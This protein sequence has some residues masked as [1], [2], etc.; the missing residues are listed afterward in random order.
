MR[1][2]LSI[3]FIIGIAILTMCCGAKQSPIPEDFSLTFNWNTGA[4]P[5]QYRYEYVITIG[6][7]F[8]GEL[9]FIPGYDGAHGSERWATPF[10]ISSEELENL[11]AFFTDNDLL[12]DR[13]NTGREL[14]GGSTTSL[15]ITAFGKEYQIPSVS[16][17]EGEDKQLVEMAME[18]IRGVVP[19]MIWEEM[20]DRQAQYENNYK[21]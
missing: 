20:N 14:I 8:Q 6:P 13:W 9:D 4:L 18:A 21:D 10:E 7:G 16:E 19:E 15:I 1:A 11:Y 5:P 17:L 2:V 3:V 12:R